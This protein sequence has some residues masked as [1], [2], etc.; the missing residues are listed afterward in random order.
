MS[1]VDALPRS[2]TRNGR[3]AR[4]GAATTL[5][6]ERAHALPSHVPFLPRPDRIAFSVLSRMPS[7]KRSRESHRNRVDAKCGSE[8][9]RT[10]IEGPTRSGLGGRSLARIL[11]VSPVRVDV[12]AAPTS[13]T[14]WREPVALAADVRHGIVAGRAPGLAARETRDG[15]P[16]AAPRNI[17]R[18]GL[19]GIFRARWQVAAWPPEKRLQCPP[20]GVNGRLEQPRRRP[21]HYAEPDNRCRT[22][23]RTFGRRH[24]RP[25]RGMFRAPPGPGTLVRHGRP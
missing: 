11:N 6:N 10:R 8:V 2:D 13:I 20:I 24:H 23:A 7:R 14:P 15:Q 12:A 19:E 21:P 18:D 16:E 1:G 4:N 22:H 9:G 5:T 17:E 25:A 3:P